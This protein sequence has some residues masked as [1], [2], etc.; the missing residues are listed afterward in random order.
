MSAHR[1]TAD[2][3]DTPPEA[4]DTIDRPQMICSMR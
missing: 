3:S 1:L 2:A 4:R